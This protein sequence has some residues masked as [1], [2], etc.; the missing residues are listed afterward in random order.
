MLRDFSLR[1]F[2]ASLNTVESYTN[3]SSQGKIGLCETVNKQKCTHLGMF[4]AS[5]I[6]QL[7]DQLSFINEYMEGIQK[8]LDRLQDSSTGFGIVNS[9]WDAKLI[10]GSHANGGV[11]D[12]TGLAQM[13]G[14]KSASETVFNARDSKK[15]YDLVHG[16]DSLIDMF[17]DKLNK[18]VYQHN[19]NAT[20][21]KTTNIYA[22]FGDIVSNNPETF[23][24]F[25]KDYLERVKSESGIF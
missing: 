22:T 14:T 13:H 8:I 7:T 19:A 12:Y 3:E 24:K 25:M 20:N 11:V 4:L 9:A 1:D 23:A 6:Q 17:R 21:N 10:Q 18:T 2:G 16:S 15:L 5:A